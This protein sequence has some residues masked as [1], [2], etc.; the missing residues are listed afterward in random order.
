MNGLDAEDGAEL[1][2]EPVEGQLARERHELLH[3]ARERDALHGRRDER[4]HQ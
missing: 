3:L 4:R 1:R 2:E